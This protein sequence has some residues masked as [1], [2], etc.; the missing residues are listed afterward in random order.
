MTNGNA[1]TTMVAKRV[2]SAL[3]IILNRKE[4]R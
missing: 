4:P 1:G 2:I 3:K